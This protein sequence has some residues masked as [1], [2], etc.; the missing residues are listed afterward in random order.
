MLSTNYSLLAGVFYF[1][2]LIANFNL[3]RMRIPLSFVCFFVLNVF[4][5][6]FQPASAQRVTIEEAALP[7]MYLDDAS[8]FNGIRVNNDIGNSAEVLVLVSILDRTGR[9]LLQISSYYLVPPGQSSLTEPISIET[10]TSSS[11][12]HNYL[13]ESGVIPQAHLTF[14][15]EI[16]DISGASDRM[17]REQNE[18]RNFNLVL[19]YPY[20]KEVINTVRPSLFWNYIGSTK[21][22]TYRIVLKNANNENTEM[23]NNLFGPT[24]FAESQIPD[25][26]IDFPV[27]IPDLEV[28]QTYQWHVEAFLGDL[29]L[30]ETEMWTFTIEEP[31]DLEDIPF[32]RSFI[33]YT[34][35]GTEPTYYL[36]GTMK[37]KLTETQKTG[38]L[39]VDITKQRTQGSKEKSIGKKE[40]E[41]EIGD[42]FYTIDLNEEFNLKH[43]KSYIAHVSKGKKDVQTVHFVYFNPKYLKLSES[44]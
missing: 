14:C 44:E 6:Q 40:F 12:L 13:K 28:G 17:C 16:K 3:H 31:N 9:N 7:Y 24:V 21:D 35:I 41:V 11:L 19:Q 22:V 15:V 25:Q 33:D 1:L 4:L 2:L 38:R 18:I 34:E 30:G 39:K 36:L 10:R 29:S 42:N 43:N 8:L 32:S 20:D 23:R 26:F 27:N 5:L 37:I